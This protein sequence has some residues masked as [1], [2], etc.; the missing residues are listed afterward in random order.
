M[1]I[2][3]SLSFILIWPS[4]PATI[5]QSPEIP[6]SQTSDSQTS[7]SQDK[8][9]G[10]VKLGVDLVVLDAQVMDQKTSRIIGNLK[11]E[12]FVLSEDGVR[13]TITHFGQD[14]LPLSVILLVD[15]G[16]CLDP[17]GE[18]VRQATLEAL[19]RLKPEDEVAVMAFHDTVELIQGFRTYKRAAVEAL[20]RMPPHD[21]NAEH[22]FNR[23]F[24]EAAN[25]MQRAANPD[26]RRVIIMITGLTTSFDCSGP[27]ASETRE[28][29]LESGSVVCGLI[30]KTPAQRLENGVLGGITGI[31]GVFKA[32]TSS[33]KDF[34]EE[35]GGEVLGAKPEEIDHAFNDLV[36]HLRTRYSLG[37]VST[38]TKR[39]GSYRRIK[40]ELAQTPAKGKTRLVVKTRRGYIASKAGTEKTDSG[41]SH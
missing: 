24:Y 18:Q 22:C 27:S 2:L 40:V 3:F 14:S 41:S 7:D 5:A 32:K 35:T 29:V 26:G 39:D 1:F 30:P 28:A 17:F 12:D 20:N 10:P 11:K 9:R 31:A 38:N 23:A 19:S 16:G 34:A 8:K 37:F 13:Q 33:L 36:N 21:E 25:Y 6:K 15:R 4:L